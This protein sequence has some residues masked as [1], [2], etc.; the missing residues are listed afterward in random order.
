MYH[1][2]KSLQNA[3]SKIIPPIFP[4][5]QRSINTNNAQICSSR[6][7]PTP[8]LPLS[9]Q[10]DRRAS[11]DLFI[12]CNANQTRKFP[13]KTH[14]DEDLRGVGVRAA[15]TTEGGHHIHEAPVV[16]DAT[17]GT[18]G[19]LL[20]LLLLL[21]LGR[22]ALDL[23]GTRQRTVHLTTDQADDHLQLDVGERLHGGGAVQLAALARQLELIDVDVLQGG[24]LSL[25]VRNN[26]DVIVVFTF[27]L[28][29]I[30]G[31]VCRRLGS[32]LSM[33]YLD[34]VDGLAW[35][36]G[37]HMGVGSADVQLHFESVCELRRGAKE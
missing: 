24:D 29:E 1:I 19:L 37:Q 26:D 36:E 25:V 2:A 8:T 9:K 30:G 16:L 17:L 7:T 10:K 31:Y 14:N 15:T 28:R 35:L 6:A 34:L 32:R 20:L 13:S 23:T 11:N 12:H 4:N 27:D 22:L 21:D 5:H 33:A 3:P 18:A